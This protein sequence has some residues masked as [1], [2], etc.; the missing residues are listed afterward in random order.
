MKNRVKE[1]RKARGLR[2]EDVAALLGVSR[3]GGSRPCWGV[4]GRVALVWLLTFPACMAIGYWT[5]QI[6][7]SLL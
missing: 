1:L 3:A 4:A 6:F 7:L 2:Q 5:A